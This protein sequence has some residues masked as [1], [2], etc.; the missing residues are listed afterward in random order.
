MEFGNGIGNGLGSCLPR[1]LTLS[2]AHVH[3]AYANLFQA[4]ASNSSEISGGFLGHQ[5]YLHGAAVFQR[6]LRWL[7]SGQVSKEVGSHGTPE[8]RVG[9]LH[10]SILHLPPCY[11]MA[12]DIQ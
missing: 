6:L 3:V 7:S 2:V 1:D 12:A 5:G 9:L 10:C 8:K 11:L 4:V